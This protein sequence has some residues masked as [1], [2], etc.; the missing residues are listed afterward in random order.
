MWLVKTVLLSIALTVVLNWAI[1]R[2]KRDK[3]D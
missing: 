3:G 1:R 2:F